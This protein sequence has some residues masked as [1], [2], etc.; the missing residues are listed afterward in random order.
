MP[1]TLTVLAVP[2]FL[3]AKLAAVKLVLRVS[4]LKRLSKRVAVAVALPSY[5]LFT[6]V[7]LTTNERAVMFAVVLAVVLGGWFAASAPVKA[8]P[9]AVSGLAGPSV[10]LCKIAVASL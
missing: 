5:T 1:L 6:L 4:P 7:A 9:P 2:T 3:S 8:V 10:F